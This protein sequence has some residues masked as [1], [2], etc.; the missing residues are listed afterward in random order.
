MPLSFPGVTDQETVTD[1]LAM[2]KVCPERGED[3]DPF[4]RF[5]LGGQGGPNQ[6]TGQRRGGRQLKE[7]P[8]CF[9]TGAFRI[10]RRENRV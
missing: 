1:V 5:A 4:S 2:A 8:A 10:F 7:V 3:G 6:R 9:M